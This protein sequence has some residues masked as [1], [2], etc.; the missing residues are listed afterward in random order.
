MVVGISLIGVV[1]LGEASNISKIESFSQTKPGEYVSGELVLNQ[2]SVVAVKS[3]ASDGG[4]IP[5]QDLSLI[6]S[7]NIGSYAISY[8]SA[9]S[10]A[11]AYTSIIG[12][13]YYVVFSSTP[14]TTQVV[15]AN[16]SSNNLITIGVFA[17][18][19]LGLIIAGVIV[20]IVGALSKNPAKSQ[21][22]VI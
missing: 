22:A 6:N 18:S 4:L 12:D 13:Y 8:R 20:I 5:S 17:L 9:G 2:P 16:L 10:G 14:P 19:S 21:K 15:V 7:N 3:P 1:G 11:D